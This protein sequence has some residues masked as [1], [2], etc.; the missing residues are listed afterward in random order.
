MSSSS[1][2][3]ARPASSPSPEKRLAALPCSE[4]GTIC[5]CLTRQSTD[6]PVADPDTKGHDDRRGAVLTARVVSVGARPVPVM[7][8]R[9][10]GEWELRLRVPPSVDHLR[11]VRLVA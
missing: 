1:R 10:A 9:D 7:F 2:R 3:F 11:T 5:P 8:E 4:C 6:A